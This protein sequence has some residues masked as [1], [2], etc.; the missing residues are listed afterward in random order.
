MFLRIFTKQQ[1]ILN[2]QRRWIKTEINQVKK[3]NVLELNGKLYSVLSSTQRSQGRG[4]SHYKLELKDIKTGSKAFERVNSGQFLE[5]VELT[6][7][8]YQ[9]L[10]ADEHIHVI[11]G[12]S[13]K[14]MTL[15]AGLV[16]G[17]DFVT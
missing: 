12:S 3:G 6:H 14:E 17:I 10:Y 5:T 13:F 16:N 4:G 11:D 1:R 9:F 2:N 7:K 8:E 15:D